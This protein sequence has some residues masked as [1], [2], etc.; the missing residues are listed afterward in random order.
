M[1]I[2]NPVIRTMRKLSLR[3][4]PPG[5]TDKQPGQVLLTRILRIQSC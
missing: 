1:G 2:T 3:L 5:Y 4:L